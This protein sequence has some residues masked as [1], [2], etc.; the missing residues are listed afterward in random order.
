[1]NTIFK[2]FIDEVLPN[3]NKILIQPFDYTRY[4]LFRALLNKNVSQQNYN[5]ETKDNIETP[6]IYI[7]KKSLNENASYSQHIDL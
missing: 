1:M 2:I 4:R 7:E 3:N 6:I 5:I